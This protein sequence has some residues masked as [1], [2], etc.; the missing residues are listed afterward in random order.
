MNRFV[1]AHKT[2]DYKNQRRAVNENEL[3]SVKTYPLEKWEFENPNSQAF[4]ADYRAFMKSHETA[5]NKGFSAICSPNPFIKC[6]AVSTTPSPLIRA[7]ARAR[8]TYN[9]I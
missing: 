2:Y 8:K 3:L 6:Y 4:T 1:E 5:P 9:R 7:K